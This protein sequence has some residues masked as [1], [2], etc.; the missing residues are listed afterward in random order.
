M[1]AYQSMKAKLLP[2]GL[3]AFSEGGAVDCELKA[4]AAE[5]DRLYGEIDTL[6]RE[7]FIATAESYGLS[8]R[9]RFAGKVRDDLTVAERRALLMESEQSCYG[10]NDEAALEQ[11]IHHLG[12][13]HYA[14]ECRQRFSTLTVMLYET[15][16]NWQLAALTKQVKAFGPVT[17][18]VIVQ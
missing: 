9:E 5:L 17:F 10:G 7:A 12:I 16:S 11:I 3:Y 14:I 15:V 2:L 13:T 4:Y 18:N 1:T 8:E 6:Y